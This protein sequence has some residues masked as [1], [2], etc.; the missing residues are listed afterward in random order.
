M[1]RGPPGPPKGSRR[2]TGAEYGQKLSYWTLQVCQAKEV[3]AA[4]KRSREARGW[5]PF[6]VFHS[7]FGIDHIYG[8]EW[9]S[10]RNSAFLYVLGLC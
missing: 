2:E 7:I 6:Y 5:G 8:K 1:V 4:S 10:S 3:I 9:Q